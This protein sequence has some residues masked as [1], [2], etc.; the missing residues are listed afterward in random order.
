MYTGFFCVRVKAV[1]RIRSERHQ[2]HNW[3]TKVH[4]MLLEITPP[5]S[6][7][8]FIFD[9]KRVEWVKNLLKNIHK[10][11]GQHILYCILVLES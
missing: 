6:R 4:Y 9:K 2:A 8:P 1:A 10:I 7:Y 11:K 5:R 3:D